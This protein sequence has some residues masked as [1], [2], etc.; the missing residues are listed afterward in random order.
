ML[1]GVAIGTSI[2]LLLRRGPGGSRPIGTYMAAAGT[3]AAT[4]GRW[5]GK[6]ASR[7]AA[8]VGERGEELR[9]RLPSLDD[10]AEEVSDYLSAARDT[11]SDTV[12]DELR[13]LR[14]SIR[15]QR[16]RIGV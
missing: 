6:R 7:G 10:V 8:W 12:S 16:K 9:D 1:M 15:K 13:D 5:A 11:I 4:A 14:K 2:T 3:G